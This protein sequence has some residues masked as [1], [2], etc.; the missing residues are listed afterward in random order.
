MKKQF[1]TA[2]VAVFAFGA[3]FAGSRFVNEGWY[4]NPTG[5][6]TRLTEAQARAMCPGGTIDCAYHF[7]QGATLPDQT[8][9]KNEN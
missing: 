1:L 5:T 3:A 9:F 7:A 8:I 2:V 6:G 4:L